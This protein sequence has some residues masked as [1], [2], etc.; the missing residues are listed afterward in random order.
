MLVEKSSIAANTGFGKK[1]ALARA[2][3]R[4]EMRAVEPIYTVLYGQD[5]WFRISYVVP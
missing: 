2:S 3:T 4:P 5:L 1:I